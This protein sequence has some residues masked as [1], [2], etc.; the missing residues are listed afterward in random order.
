[1]SFHCGHSLHCPISRDLDHLPS[2]LSTLVFSL[3][4][5]D[6]N[7][8]LSPNPPALPFLMRRAL[9]VPLTN[10]VYSS[11]QPWSCI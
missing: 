2:P 5:L 11:S 9:A 10:L 6:R 3:F 1:M 4:R 7:A 8:P